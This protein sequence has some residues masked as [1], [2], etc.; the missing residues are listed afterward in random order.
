MMTVNIFIKPCFG[1]YP[2]I[3]WLFLLRGDSGK[4]LKRI[5]LY[6]YKVLK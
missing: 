4:I 1:G 5:V 2:F 3:A 6:D